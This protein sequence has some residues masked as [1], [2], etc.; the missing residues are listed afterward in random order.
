MKL[1]GSALGQTIM[2]LDKLLKTGLLPAGCFSFRKPLLILT[3]SI[4]HLRDAK[5]AMHDAAYG[6][7][8]GRHKAAGSENG[9]IQVFAQKTE[10][11]A[12]EGNQ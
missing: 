8:R 6:H 1:D 12:A 2:M 3:M 11:T 9:I 10:H 7:G 5:A 4:A